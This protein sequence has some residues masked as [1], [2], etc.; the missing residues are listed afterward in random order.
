[1]QH[2]REPLQST[3]RM[4]LLIMVSIVYAV[5]YLESNNL[6]QEFIFPRL[7]FLM[8]T[9]GFAPMFA[10][11]SVYSTYHDF[12]TIRREIKDGMYSPIAYIIAHT[13]VQIPIIALLALCILVPGVYGINRVPWESF[14]VVFILTFVT[15]WAF[16]SL[17]ESAAVIFCTPM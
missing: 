16:E 1:M 4:L 10:I 8:W 9:V 12:H 6:K 14:G 5:N 17:G 11:T 13:L 7:S 2:S 15:I 3:G